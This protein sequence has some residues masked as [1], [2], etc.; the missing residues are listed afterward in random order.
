MIVDGHSWNRIV[1]GSNDSNFNSTRY[2][3]K[4]NPKMMTKNTPQVFY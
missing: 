1:T 4:E 2:S 3:D